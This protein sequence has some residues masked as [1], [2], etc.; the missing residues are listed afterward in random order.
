MFGKVIQFRKNTSN[1]NQTSDLPSEITNQFND[2]SLARGLQL[3]EASRISHINFGRDAYFALVSDSSGK[4]V[5]VHLTLDPG[6]K[7]LSRATCGCFRSSTRTYCHHIVT[8][9][10]YIL[11]PDPE[12]GKLRSMCDDFQAGFWYEMSWYGYKNFGDSILGFRAYVNHGDESLRITFSDRNKNEILAFMP[13]A[14][15]VEEHLHEFFE[16]ICRDIDPGVF[17]SMYGRKLKDC[18][19]PSLRRRPWNFSV[20]EDEIN[21][22]GVKSNRQ[23]YED[24]I[25][26]RIAKVG[27]LAS[28]RIK[29]DFNFRFLEHKEGLIVEGLDQEGS[30]ILR[31]APPRT[32]IGSIIELGEKKGALGDD[33]LIN[34]NALKTGYRIDLQEDSSLRITPIVENPDPDAESHQAYLK[35][36]DL[37]HQLF[38]SYYFFPDNYT[39]D[40]KNFNLWYVD[41][42]NEQGNWK[43]WQATGARMYL[44]PNWWNRSSFGPDITYKKNGEMLAFCQ[45]NGMSGFRID[46]FKDNW[47]LQ[48]LNYYVLA[49]QLYTTKTIEEIAAEYWMAFGA[50]A[51][52]IKEYFAKCMANSAGF[53]KE[54]LSSIADEFDLSDNANFTSVEAIPGLFPENFRESLRKILEKAE[55]KTSGTDK[56][57]VE[58]L[59][60]GLMVT[61]LIS[62]YVTV[63]LKNPQQP[64]GTDIL[65]K[66]IKEI[67]VKY[68]YSIT[69]KSFNAVMKRKFKPQNQGTKKK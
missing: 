57:R 24:S 63:A 69:A 9:I 2:E 13:G 35:R 44:R 49:R 7:L 67:E 11:R 56:A 8:F 64:P 5:N 27:F 47:S 38:G 17:K 39:F 53:N 46:G 16:I 10:R 30:V 14:C 68:P 31:L 61:D 6:T 19:V 54:L 43:K 25:W 33:L 40:G 26:H 60:S 34:T 65:A 1:T 22:K 20:S 50:A 59:K 48:G 29:Q 32:H 3:A 55:Q 66:K 41:R 45:K 18:N 42:T 37:E 28:G 15:L 36:P 58:W 62:D 23:Q 12:T 21:R 51:P 52:E 4:A